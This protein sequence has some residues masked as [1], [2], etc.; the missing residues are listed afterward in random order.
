MGRTQEA[1]ITYLQKPTAQQMPAY[2]DAPPQN[3]ADVYAY[4]RSLKSDVLPVEK[5]PLLT[6]TLK[7]VQSAK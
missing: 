7:R 4:I 6:E 5:I 3:L 1:F 2:A